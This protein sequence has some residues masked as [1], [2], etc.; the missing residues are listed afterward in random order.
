[1]LTW[2]IQGFDYAFNTL[3]QGETDELVRAFMEL[4]AP[5]QSPPT[6]AFLVDMFPLLGLIVRSLIVRAPEPTD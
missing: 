3:S 5:M 2:V 6:I 4:F 1:M